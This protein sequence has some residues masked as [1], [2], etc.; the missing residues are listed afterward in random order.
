MKAAATFACR[1]DG[2]GTTVWPRSAFGNKGTATAAASANATANTTAAAPAAARHKKFRHRLVAKCRVL[3]G[4]GVKEV[5]ELDSK[6]CG[7]LQRFCGEAKPVCVRQ[8]SVEIWVFI[9]KA[10]LP[11]SCG[12]V[13]LDHA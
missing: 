3:N 8:A 10:L 9:D 1:G 4:D 2:S 12:R 7:Y 11:A 6:I 5:R 13:V